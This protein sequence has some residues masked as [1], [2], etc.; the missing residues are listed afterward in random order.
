MNFFKPLL[1][2][3]TALIALG[4]DSCNHP[5][6]ARLDIPRACVTETDVNINLPQ[7]PE[8]IMLEGRTSKS[9]VLD[10]T[11]EFSAVRETESQLN[12]QLTSV[13]A[14]LTEGYESFDFLSDIELNA[15]PI[16]QPSMAAI[17]TIPYALTDEDRA[18]YTFS[19]D[20]DERVN[21]APHLQDGALNVVLN[22]YGTLPN[23]DH[24]TL[25]ITACFTLTLVR[26]L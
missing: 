21:L 13:T 7:L 23:T 26:D 24:I 12:L 15:Y 19:V 4:N 18:G 3:A 8:H 20:H 16:A 25:D 9:F 17:L 5:F 6:G 10:L 2:T 1:I 22:M 14:V 11:D